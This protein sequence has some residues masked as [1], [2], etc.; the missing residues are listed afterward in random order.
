MK[1]NITVH[2]C[3]AFARKILCSLGSSIIADRMTVGT[4]AAF[5]IISIN[6]LI[7]AVLVA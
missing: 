3:C 4:V 6:R 1:W 7:G 2:L 5:I